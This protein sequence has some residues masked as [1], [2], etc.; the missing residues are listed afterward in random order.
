MGLYST[1]LRVP[2]WPDALPPGQIRHI[3]LP[4]AVLAG[5][6]ILACLLLLFEVTHHWLDWPIFLLIA[7][8]QMAICGVALRN[9]R[10]LRQRVVQAGVNSG[11]L[12]TMRKAK[13][14]AES[15]NLAKSRYLANVSHEIRSPLNAIYGYAQLVESD[16]GVEAQEAASVIRRCAEQMSTLIEGLLDISQVEHGVLR[17]NSAVVRLG[18]F[19][20]QL[21]GMVRQSAEAKG[22][23]LS[24]VSEGRLPE[25]V[26]TDQGRLRQVLLNLLTN[27]I[28]FTDHGSVTLW[29]R[30]SGQIAT[31]EVRDTGPGIRPQ[32][33]LAIFDPFERGGTEQAQSRPGA[34][35]GLSI[36]RAIVGILGGEL[37]LADSS[38]AGSIF[39]VTL[40]LG[41]VVGQP[42]LP[43]IKRRITGYD[44]PRR[45]LLV[46]DD[47]AGQRD[48]VT[49]L[50]RKLGFTV[51]EAGDGETALALAGEKAFDL[52]ILDITMPGI[53]GWQVAARLRERWGEK[54]QILMLSAN[55]AEMHGPE[56]RSQLH[57][58]F[59][60]KPVEFATLTGALGTLLKLS[61]IMAMSGGDESRAAPGD[62]ASE[63]AVLSEQAANHARHLR[64]LLRIGYVRGMEEEIRHLQNEA[65]DLAK[66]LFIC[67]DRFD[68]GSMAVILDGIAA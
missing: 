1:D 29:L 36:S 30:Y 19:I 58:H 17:L 55:S 67:L 63:P 18:P 56:F 21:M 26:R 22:L 40:M 43:K 50:L 5:S 16:Y 39:R 41:E 10:D 27:A 9:M 47:D 45:K 15:V 60:I 6:V 32:D 44:G 11:E 24:F 54:L 49:C 31:F 7:L 52:V 8:A 20:S 48:F 34:G 59:L 28:K 38:S 61:W 12:Q 65:P 57:D 51:F 35:L 46:V 64:E 42:Q 23:T 14:A 4:L 33:R 13:D 3:W 66:E 2:E 68:L 25:Y 62:K 53:S 37:E